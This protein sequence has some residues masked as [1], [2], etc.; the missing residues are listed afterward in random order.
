MC[1]RLAP[2]TLAVASIA[3]L[4]FS[5]PACNAVRHP[6]AAGNCPRSPE[7]VAKVE[8]LLVVGHRGAAG[9]EIENTIP[10]MQRAIAD[11]A[12]AVEID[13]SMTK[14][15]VIVLWHD[16]DPDTSVA[17]TRQTHVEPHQHARPHVPN[18]GSK[19]RKPVDELT[20]AELR[21]HYG[22][23]V[24]GERAQTEIPTLD[25]FLDWAVNERSLALV[26]FDMK[27]PKDRA[28][29][30]E[31]L[32]RKVIDA[33]AARKPAWAHVFL[34]P[35]EP[36]YE[37]AS[38]IVPGD[39]LAFDADP[40]IVVIDGASCEDSSSER[41]VRRGSG[42]AST[43]VP[44]GVAPEAWETLQ[45]L[46]SC[47]LT[48]RDRSAPPVPKKV[49]VATLNERDQLECVLDMG[50][51]G[52]LTDDPGSLRQIAVERGRTPFDPKATV[53]NLARR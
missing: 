32:F 14:D 5:A 21:E 43:V 37:R 28:E 34:T 30:T 39:A 44:T 42:Y 53:T 47:D 41:A 31:P 9:K 52:I 38:T 51:D 7:R 4:V 33:V 8:K 13:L 29:L 27:L 19:M 11:G 24:D 46:L 25:Q 50:V 10:S 45:K 3:C 20:L 15:G 2:L 18:K 12:N 35:H 26:L 6:T 1:M 48:A 23:V 16:W 36:V 17:V 49:F 40:G 22:Y